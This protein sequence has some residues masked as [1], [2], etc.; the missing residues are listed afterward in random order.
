MHNDSIETLLLRHYGPTAPNPTYLEQRLIAS[1]RQEATELQ[2]QQLVATR[3]RTKH[4]SRRRVMG[5]VAL[6]SAGLGVLSVSLE[7]LQKLEA[8]LLGQDTTQ[9][10][11]AL[12]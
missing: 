11:P 9:L 6:S 2:Q 7:S 10:R 4:V 1:V 12:S 3:L 8:N 5:L